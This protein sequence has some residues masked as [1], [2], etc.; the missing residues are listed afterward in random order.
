MRF[1]N[2]SGG[3]RGLNTLNGT[4]LIEP[5][6]T[7]AD[8]K[9]SEAEA[10]IAEA[11][12][13]FE[14]EGEPEPD[15]PQGDAVEDLNEAFE[16]AR[17]E[18]RDQAN[19]A[20]KTIQNN[21]A[22]ALAAEKKRADEAEAALTQARAD[23]ETANTKLAASTQAGGNTE[24]PAVAAVHRGAGSYSIM[25][26]DAELKGGLTKDEAATF[27]GKTDAEKAAEV[28]SFPNGG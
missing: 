25:R 12:G 26:G 4:I 18:V 3:P 1:T 10:K 24:P 8:V 17:Q 27:N 19:A 20:I 9:V 23:L 6:E 7:S 14:I 16:R 28:A 13:W 21:H 5:K 2:I 22:E 15:A 11:S